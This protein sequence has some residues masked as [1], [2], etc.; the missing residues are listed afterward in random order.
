VGN[1]VYYQMR[2]GN[3]RTDQYTVTYLRKEGYLEAATSGQNISGTTNVVPVTD[4]SVYD[5][6]G[7]RVAVV[8][9]TQYAGG[10]NVADTLRSFAYDGN[11]QIIS[12]RD[13]TDKNGAF[14]QGTTSA[15]Q[16]QH[17]MYVNGNQVGHTDEAGKLDILTQ[18]TA[19]SSGPSSGYV[20]QVGDTLKSIAQAVHGNASLWYV[21]AQA[22]AIDSDA[23]LAIGQDLTIPEVKTNQNDATTFKPYNPGEIAGSTTPTLPTIAPPVPPPS[24]A[25]WPTGGLTPAAYAKQLQ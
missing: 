9:H 25:R 14:D 15:A 10:S 24:T 4:Q 19:F 7:N 2:T 13:G 22:N 12:R 23:G 11:G 17:Y 18:V 21:I 6:R 3:T 5:R 20:V 8:Q 16:N 1:I